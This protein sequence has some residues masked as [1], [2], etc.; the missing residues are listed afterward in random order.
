MDSLSLIR[1][2]GVNKSLG[3]WLDTEIRQI[4][5]LIGADLNG[6]HIGHELSRGIPGA[7]NQGR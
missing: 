7:G 6:I 4:G 3:A 5:Y 2:D 1:N